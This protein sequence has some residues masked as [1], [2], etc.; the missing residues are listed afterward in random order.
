MEREAL[1]INSTWQ[2]WLKQ[3]SRSLLATGHRS[4]PASRARR[5]RRPRLETLE[6]RT[7][8]SVT[9]APTNNNGQGYTALDFNHSGGYV[10]PDT[11]GAAGPSAYVETVNQTVGLYGSKAT[12]TPATTS[13]LSNFWF[14]TGGLGHADG[15]SGLSDPVVTYNDQIGRF[16]VA[17]QDVDFNTHVSRFDFAVSKTSSPTTLGTSDW[18]FYQVNT[19]QANEDADYPGNFGYNHDATV[20]TLNMFAVPGTGGTNHVQVISVNNA[21]LAANSTS[22]HIYQ[23]NL[24]DFSVRPT[25]MHD[26]V[27][28]DPMWLVTEHGDGK[29]ID[30]IKMTNVL[31]TSASFAYT[32]LQVTA[33]SG[34]VDPRNPNGTIITNNIDSR[35]QKSAEW[36][37]TIVATHAV[38]VSSTQDVAQ[39]YKIDVSSGTPTLADQG[40]VSFGNNTYV[41]YPAIDINSSGLIGMTFMKSGTDSSTDYMSMYVTGRTPSDAAGTMET[42]VIVP[43]GTGVANYKD[44]SGGGRAGDLGG[45]NVDPSDGSFWGAN[46]FANTEANAN[47]GTAVANFT[48]SSPL[49]SADMSVTA[50]GPSSVTAGTNAT[51]TVTLTNNGPNAAQGV[52][53]TDTL[54]SGSNFVSMTQTS[55]NDGFTL[56]QSG[57]TATE[58]A[59]GSIASGS[60]DA[61]TLVVFAPSGLPNGAA[62]NDTASVSA[63]NPDPNTGNNTITVTGTVVNNNPNADLA[64]TA[65]GPS[66]ANEGDTVTYTLTVTNSGPSTATGVTLTDTLASILS[67]KSATTSQGTFTQSGGV[68]TFSLGT[69]ANGGTVTATVVAQATEDGSASDSASV[70]SSTP[71]PNSG[72]N[73]ASVVTSFSEAAISVSAPIHTR[74]HSLTNFQVATFTHANGVEPA[75]AFVATIDWGDGTTSQGNITQS[76]TTYTVTGSHTYGNGKNHT[77]TTTVTEVGN[78]VVKVSPDDGKRGWK[79]QDVVHEP[80]NSGGNGGGGGG[81][82]QWAVP[83]GQPGASKTSTPP[84]SQ[85]VG[86]PLSGTAGSVAGGSNAQA[87]AVGSAVTASQSPSGTGVS[88]FVVSV[89]P[90]NQYGATTDVT[91]IR[92][93]AGSNPGT[94]AA[95]VFFTLG[96]EA[97]GLPML[98]GKHTGFDWSVDSAA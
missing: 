59:T 54:P 76:G 6:N 56:S 30:V 48:I 88:S 70:S 41:Y 10:P 37:N 77:I 92:G 53:L 12:G 35:I 57:G 84:S 50:T 23:N 2:K 16:I 15:G 96:A 52:V 79:F 64:V 27:A 24:N 81:G 40:R 80:G 22:P 5:S 90:S 97:F 44:F 47:W 91:P 98:G 8:P 20:F 14:T 17:D 78:G 31:S 19:T 29:S 39:W 85:A 7:L 1:M 65:S 68:V 63:S 93:A 94:A 66:T 61:F 55:G 36:N 51:Y 43:A 34:V 13:S 72:N 11:Q 21:D 4:R 82:G 71:D 49:P 67:F 9:I 83:A 95:D 89:M 26:S 45:I 33:Y 73:S 38:S 3:M 60:S 69:I 87:V 58:T 62:F 75:S 46:E 25:T 74:S 18:T 86:A 28:G 42:P 32:N